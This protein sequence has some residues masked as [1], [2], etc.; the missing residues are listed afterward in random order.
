MYHI[1]LNTVEVYFFFVSKGRKKKR[2][3]DDVRG[4]VQVGQ[5]VGC[6]S[7]GGI[8]VCAYIF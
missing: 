4:G 7:C 3:I 1:V 2:R 5:C 8:S 6:L